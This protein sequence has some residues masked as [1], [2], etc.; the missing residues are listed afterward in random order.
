M[1][2]KFLD[3]IRSRRTC[4]SISPKSPISDERILEIAREVI[5]HTP[6]SFN[7]QSTRFVILLQHQHVRFWEIAKECFKS[8]LSAVM[9]SE[10]EKKLSGR[11]DGYGTILLFEDSAT[12]REFQSKFPRFKYHLEDFSEANNA[13]QAVNLWTALHLEGFGCNLQ[14]VNPTVDQRV[15]S[16]WNVPP[17]WSLKAQLVFGLPTGELSHEKVFKSTDER[18]MVP[19]MR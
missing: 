13:I 10:Y 15:T 8:T 19:G 18:I 5:K 3:I 16:E 14:H 9:Y 17:A 12:I 7:C 1:S 11:Q 2:D 6:S 4:Y